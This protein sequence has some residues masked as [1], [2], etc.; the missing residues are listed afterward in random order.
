MVKLAYYL[1]KYFDENSN[2]EKKIFENQAFK[3]KMINHRKHILKLR[4][5]SLTE[6]KWNKAYDAAYKA[7]SQAGSYDAQEI[8]FKSICGF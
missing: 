5:F 1:A 8:I 3:T 7:L 6:G 4:I 2:H